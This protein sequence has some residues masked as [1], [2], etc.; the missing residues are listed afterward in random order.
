MYIQNNCYYAQKIKKE[1]YCVEKVQY[2]FYA[3][4]YENI[5]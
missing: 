4:R 3:A 1:K 5:I 2:F